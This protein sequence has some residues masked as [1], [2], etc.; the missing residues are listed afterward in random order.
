MYAINK[1]FRKGDIILWS[2]LISAIRG[3]WHL[4]DGTNGTPNLVDLFVICAGSSY[5]VGATGGS[6]NHLHDGATDGHS[7]TLAGGSQVNA[8]GGHSNNTDSQ[9]DAFTTNTA[10]HLPSYYALAYIM[11]L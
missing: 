6:V 9:T 10:N 5:V 2:G 3:G 1:A 4:C 8:G 11:K 7:H